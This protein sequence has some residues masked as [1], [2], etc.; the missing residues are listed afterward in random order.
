MHL[1]I[2]NAKLFNPKGHP[3]HT[4]ADQ[5]ADRLSRKNC[6]FHRVG[7]ACCRRASCSGKPLPEEPHA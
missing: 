4:S 7:R 1:V 2:D 5:L 6:F 3:V